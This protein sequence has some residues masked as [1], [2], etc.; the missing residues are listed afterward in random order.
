MWKVNLIK[1]CHLGVIIR[2]RVLKW[3]RFFF[4]FFLV[5]FFFC[6]YFPRLHNTV[7]MIIDSRAPDNHVAFLGVSCCCTLGARGFLRE[8]PRSAIS[9]AVKREKIVSSRRKNHKDSLHEK[10]LNS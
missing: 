6:R 7:F 9:E 10:N 5:F 8:E 2:H 1:T 3:A 4:S